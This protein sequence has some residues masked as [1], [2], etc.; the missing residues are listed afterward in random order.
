MK[1]VIKRTI[2]AG[3]MGGKRFELTARAESDGDLAA[4]FKG[5]SDEL[6]LSFRSSFADKSVALKRSDLLRGTKLNAATLNELIELE[7]RLQ[8]GFEQL[9]RMVEIMKAGDV[10]V[11]LA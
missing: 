2:K 4:L 9:K 8:A 7:D 1:L 11:S 3:L 10:E 6:V 5:C